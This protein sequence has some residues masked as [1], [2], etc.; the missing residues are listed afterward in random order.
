MG[1]LFKAPPKP[2]KPAPPSVAEPTATESKRIAE[3]EDKKRVAASSL[4]QSVR[5]GA[6]NP[7]YF[8]G[9]KTNQ[10]Q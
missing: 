2:K 1:S 6:V 4:R 5:G 3:K 10:G 8:P 9:T 7:A